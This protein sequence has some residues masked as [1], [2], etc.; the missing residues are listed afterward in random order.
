M[1]LYPLDTLK[2]FGIEDILI[3]SGGNHLGNFADFLG[4]GREYGVNLT[5]RVQSQA[6]GIAQALGLAEGFS[7]GDEVMVILGDN[8]F[9][10][11]INTPFRK[12]NSADDLAHI[13]L[14]KVPDASRF[15]VC[16]FDEKKQLT[17]IIEKPADPPS[18]WAVTGLYKYPASVFDFI[19]TLHPSA[20]GEFEITDVNN[21]FLSNG[22][23]TYS[24]IRDNIFW[25]D[26]GTPES[27]F[28][29]TQ[30]AYKVTYPR[31]LDKTEMG[32]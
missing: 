6:G 17:G 22:K 8:I 29:A 4:D 11:L 30:F 19:R 15:G 23:L 14:K 18:R 9:G 25:S 16:A 13:W 28:K 7:N 32:D 26:A 21:W 24:H 12:K 31:T 1:I 10:D 5:Y 27:L 3:I 2:S 20:R